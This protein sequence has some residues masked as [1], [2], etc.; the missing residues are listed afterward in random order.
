MIN[1]AYKSGEYDW[2]YANYLPHGK[3]KLVTTAL[4]IIARSD[5]RVAI[6]L[7]AG[8]GYMTQVLCEQ[9]P[10]VLAV[11]QSEAMLRSMAVKLNPFVR[12]KCNIW[13]LALDLN[14]PGALPHVKRSLNP[15]HGADLIVC[16]QGIGYLTPE[17]LAHIPDLLTPGGSFL[18]NAF[19]RPRRLRFR[20]SGDIAEAG[21]FA[22]G[23]VLHLQGRWPKV[24][25]TTFR[26]HDIP[27]F[28]GSLWSQLGYGV[29]LN[30]K[31]RTVLCEVQKPLLEK[32]LH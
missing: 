3:D 20:L 7:C 17:T 13:G 31:G 4:Q 18:F 10:N 11:D 9:I 26:W 29:R 12:L 28:F 19:V 14:T 25:L 22:F 6:D 24:D 27:G 23:R 2:L 8:T 30:V 1:R 15:F 32:D 21:L 5:P 16:R